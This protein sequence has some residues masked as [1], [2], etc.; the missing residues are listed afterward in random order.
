MR[1]EKPRDLAEFVLRGKSGWDPERIRDAMQSGESQSISLP[2]SIPV[3]IV[4]WTAW[5]DEDGRVQLRDDIYGLDELT[6]GVAATHQ[7][8]VMKH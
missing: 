7:T 6:H 4:Y 5:V 3:H 1:V 8:A 2:E